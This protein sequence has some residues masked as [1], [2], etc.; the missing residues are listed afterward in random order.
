[1]KK[2]ILYPLRGIINITFIALATTMAALGIYIVA[3]ITCLLPTR[4]L[5]TISRYFLHRFPIYWID[6]ISLSINAMGRKKWQIEGPIAL[7]PKKP[8]LLISNHVSGLDILAL[9]YVFHRKTPCMKFFM[10][11]ELLWTLP[12]AGFATWLLGY[13]FMERHTRA[14]VRKNPD[15]K[16]KDLETTKKACKKFVT[17]PATIMNYVEGTRFSEEKRLNMHSPYHHLLKPKVAGIAVVMNEIHQD[18]GGI[19]DATLIYDP[20]HISIW[21]FCCGNFDRIICHYTLLPIQ[22]ELLGDYFTDREYRKRIQAW[23][24]TRWQEKDEQIQKTR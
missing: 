6:L 22:S 20:Q 7:D 23:L 24:N 2:Y 19:I 13:P 3:A 14:Q 16:N 8:Y 15:L 5:R 18:L 4:R 9:S 1:M 12:F 11:K 10:K 17:Y 21:R